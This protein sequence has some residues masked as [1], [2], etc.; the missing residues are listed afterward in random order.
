L[1]FRA[2]NE[3]ARTLHTEAANVRVGGEYRLSPFSVRLGTAVYGNPYED[4]VVS[5]SKPRMIYTGG[6]G[7]KAGNTYVDFSYKHRSFAS[8]YYMYNPEYVQVADIEHR[9]H[10]VSVT[11]GVRF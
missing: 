9:D 2:D 1:D 8:D 11:M 5:N 10:S 7:Y 6:V 4:G 3:L